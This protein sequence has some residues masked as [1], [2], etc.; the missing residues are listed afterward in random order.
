MKFSNK[1]IRFIYAWLNVPLH[2][3]DVRARHRFLKMVQSQ[4][5]D[6]ETERVALI[7]KYANKDQ[8]GKLILEKNA[9]GIGEY[10]FTE[11]RRALFDEE[12]FALLNKETKYDIEKEEKKFIRVVKDILTNKLQKGLSI[13]EGEIYDSVLMEF[14]HALV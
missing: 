8:D 6:M 5:N 11:E 1:E 14:D 7:E 12:S 3:E 13:D 9:Q 10:K 2:G 4:L